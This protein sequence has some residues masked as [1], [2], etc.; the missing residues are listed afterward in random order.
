MCLEL[1]IVFAIS[2]SILLEN[3]APKYY[4]HIINQI[5]KM[6]IMKKILEG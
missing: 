4:T 3:H 6:D 5:Y 2:R 1:M